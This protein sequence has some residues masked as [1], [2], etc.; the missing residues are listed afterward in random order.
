[1]TEP[2]LEQEPQIEDA[3]SLVPGL[4][5]LYAGYLAYR[6]AQGTLPTAW[7]Q[8]VTKLQLSTY[9][10]DTLAMIAAR[11]L[12]R[13]REGRGAAADSLWHGVSQGV[14]A[15]VNTGL[16]AIAEALQWTEQQEDEGGVATK[17]EGGPVP[18]MSRPPVDLAMTV[19][20]AVAASAQQEAARVAGWRFKVWDTA[21]DANVRES[22]AAL[23][24]TKVE[25]TKAFTTPAGVALRF[26][27]DPRAP[28]EERIGC[29]CRLHTV[30]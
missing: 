19:A 21:G 4:L 2:E 12:A 3:S 28:I 20:Q 23:N 9:V 7:T 10:G 30:R 5:A 13:Q 25:I 26:P 15:G 11:A 14:K 17:D 16:Q 27:G 8:V 1:M 29:R 18:T 22:H 24:G 6:S